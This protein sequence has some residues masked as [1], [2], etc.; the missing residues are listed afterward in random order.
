MLS[1]FQ[2]SPPKN[3][4]P[5]PL[6]PA[7]LLPLPCTGFPLYWVIE[8]SQDQGP[9]LPLMANKAILCY[10]CSWS[11]G[12]LHVYFLVGGLVPGSS[13]GTG[14]FIL[15]LL[16]GCKPLNSLGLFSSS[17][18][19]DPVLCPVVGWEHRLLCLSGIDR[20]SLETAI[21]GSCQQALVGIHKSVWVWWLYTE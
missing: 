10:I 15:F 11:H 21:S 4:C 6:P 19:G 18:T 16:W 13:R 17:S 2:V 14:W 20:A 5:I 7:H 3:P 9:L 1:S 12:S 8:P